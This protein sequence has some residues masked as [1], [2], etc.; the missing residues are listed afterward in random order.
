MRR[1]VAWL[2][3]L[4]RIS[5]VVLVLLVVVAVT[6]SGRPGLCEDSLSTA[7]SQL[8]HGKQLVYLPVTILTR[9]ISA[10]HKYQ[11]DVSEEKGAIV[12]MTI[13]FDL[14]KFFSRKVGLTQLRLLSRD[15][16]CHVLSKFGR[17]NDSVS[18][19]KIISSPIRQTE[20]KVEQ[21]IYAKSSY[22][23]NDCSWIFVSY[24]CVEERHLKVAYSRWVYDYVICTPLGIGRRGLLLFDMLTIVR[25]KLQIYT[26]L[27]DAHDCDR[28]VTGSDSSRNCMRPTLKR[29]SSEPRWGGMGCIWDV[30]TK[31]SKFI[32][33]TS[34]DC[35][36][37]TLTVFMRKH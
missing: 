5:L 28:F 30:N 32:Q 27:R 34:K 8:I 16:I 11:L 24:P 13:D 9:S 18:K 4:F 14:G 36:M 21:S 1:W 19:K 15:T 33:E 26:H 20:T 25:I 10:T 2:L 31:R 29:Y 3:Y 17:R 22:L 12:G 7:Y 6:T 37:Y 23:K 35:S